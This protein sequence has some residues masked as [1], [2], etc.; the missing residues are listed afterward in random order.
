[1]R[2]VLVGCATVAVAAVFAVVSH[3][4]CTVS[5]KTVFVFIVKDTGRGINF[6]F[7]FPHTHTERG[8]ANLHKVSHAGTHRQTHMDVETDK[9]SG[10]R[11]I[12]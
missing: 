3:T 4:H 2:Q 9:L 1:M 11:Q 8:E 6:Y 7:C 5:A 12:E 10:T